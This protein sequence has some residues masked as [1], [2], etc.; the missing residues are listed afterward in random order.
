MKEKNKKL[1]NKKLKQLKSRKSK[2]K[3]FKFLLNIN[4]KKEGA[5]NGN[6]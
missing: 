6:K 2:I 1:N 5:K 4:I 3:E